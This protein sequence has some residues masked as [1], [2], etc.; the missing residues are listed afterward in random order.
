MLICTASG[1]CCY[2]TVYPF[3]RKP[4]TFAVNRRVPASPDS[5]ATAA[6]DAHQL[7]AYSRIAATS[8]PGTRLRRLA[9]HEPAKFTHAPAHLL[10]ASFDRCAA[11]A[12]SERRVV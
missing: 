1:H 5:L 6:V 11:H 9:T 8:D 10:C 2:E 7:E 12:Q 3:A 4:H